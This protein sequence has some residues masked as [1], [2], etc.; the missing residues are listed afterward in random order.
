MKVMLGRETRPLAES[1][2]TEDV[3]GWIRG[4]SA[5]EFLDHV[6]I[7]PTKRTTFDVMARE[8]SAIAPSD[9]HR[10]FV[11]FYNEMTRRISPKNLSSYAA[12]CHTA[13]LISGMFPEG[14]GAI[15]EN[16]YRIM[17]LAPIRAK[18]DYH[19]IS[20]LTSYLSAESVRRLLRE[21]KLIVRSVDEMREYCAGRSYD[22]LASPSLERTI[23]YIAARRVMIEYG[24]WMR[25]DTRIV[26]GSWKGKME[27]ALMLE[28]EHV[29]VRW[30]SMMLSV[31]ASL[32]DSII[33]RLDRAY[34][35]G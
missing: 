15:A 20:S 18:P 33:P 24:L 17:R 26:Y 11:R 14:N 21:E 7:Q 32:A 30:F 16:A 25:P 31:T 12:M 19:T 23:D 13:I 27:R 10:Q 3:V 4:H 29:R 5:E 9:A 1:R 2:S 6:A 22:D 8:E 28:R 35:F 34:G